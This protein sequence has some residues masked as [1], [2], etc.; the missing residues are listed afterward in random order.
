MLR[1]DS[2]DKNT[3]SD[4]TASFQDWNWS[5]Y[6]KICNKVPN[7]L[8]FKN[9]SI[10]WKTG[11]IGMRKSYVASCKLSRHSWCML[12]FVIFSLFIEYQKRQI[13]TDLLA[14]IFYKFWLDYFQNDLS[15][16]SIWTILV[17]EA[18]IRR[19]RSRSIFM[20]SLEFTT[21]CFLLTT[22]KLEPVPM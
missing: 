9:V 3:M 2:C 22:I 4:V 10:Y 6:A 7:N 13:P 19:N 18:L 17:C 16:L 1:E 8:L 21:N 15:S 11:K 14:L 5:K 12:V 20:D